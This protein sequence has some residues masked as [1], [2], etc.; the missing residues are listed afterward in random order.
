MFFC[1]CEKL[2]TKKKVV[3]WH[4]YLNFSNPIVTF[5]RNCMNCFGVWW[6]PQPFFEKVVLYLVL[7][8][9]NWWQSH[10]GP[11]LM[12]WRWWGKT[13]C[14][15]MNVN[16]FTTKL[17]WNHLTKVSRAQN[18]L[19]ASILYNDSQHNIPPTINLLGPIIWESSQ[20]NASGVCMWFSHITRASKCNL[21]PQPCIDL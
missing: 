2:H 13:K 12:V 3:S 11:K 19:G 17:G 9:I 6:V 1:I 18:P 10:L 8:I 20:G 7:E 16:F 15:K 4:V 14:Q 5:W 21:E